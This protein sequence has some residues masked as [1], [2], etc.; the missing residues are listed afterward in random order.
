MMNTFGAQIGA[1]CDNNEVNVKAVVRKIAFE[2]FRKAILKTPVDTGRAR[3]NW[4]VAIGAPNIGSPTDAVDQSGTA[5]LTSAAQGVQSWQGQGSIFMTN[6]LPY[7][8]RLEYG[9]YPSPPKVATGKTA[10]G[11]SIQAPNGMVRISMDEIVT[12]LQQGMK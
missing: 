5:A 10:G 2:L 9:G 4:G 11:F 3:A 12:F 6:N 7:I 1:F 8:G